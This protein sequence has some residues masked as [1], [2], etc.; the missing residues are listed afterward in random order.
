MTNNIFSFKIKDYAFYKL[1]KYRNF[2]EHLSFTTTEKNEALFIAQEVLA[3]HDCPNSAIFLHCFNDDLYVLLKTD[4][5]YE[6]FG[7]KR[8]DSEDQADYYYDFFA[9]TDGEFHPCCYSLWMETKPN[10]WEVV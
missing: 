4:D 1:N 9:E 5:E 10:N 6:C 2:V 3:Q 8:E 7:V